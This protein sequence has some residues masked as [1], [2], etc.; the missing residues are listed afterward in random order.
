MEQVDRKVV[1]RHQQLHL[2]QGW[3]SEDVPAE[4]SDEKDDKKS[5]STMANFLVGVTNAE[6]AKAA[7]TQEQS[8]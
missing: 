8:E 4:D 7:K 1:G 3:H 5:L 6:K 2:Q